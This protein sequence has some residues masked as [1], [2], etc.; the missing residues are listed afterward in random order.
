[1]CFNQRGDITLNSSS[2]KLL[3]KFT[4]L[5]SS[6][7]SNDTDIKTRLAKAWIG[8]DR[9]S[10][11]RKL[12]RTDKIKCSFF[13][14]AVELILSKRMEEKLDGNYIRMLRAIL[15]NSWRQQPKK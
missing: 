2:L 4:Y 13:E 3:D 14:A 6:L 10:V 15:N 1:M 5:G 12:D 11:I 7:S 9:L 8:I